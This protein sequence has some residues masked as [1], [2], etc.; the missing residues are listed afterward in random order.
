MDKHGTVLLYCIK[1]NY[2]DLFDNWMFT[3]LGPSTHRG[4]DT[5]SFRHA[6]PQFHFT[7]K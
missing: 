1:S 5:P 2:I 3:L 6:W 4:K 7:N